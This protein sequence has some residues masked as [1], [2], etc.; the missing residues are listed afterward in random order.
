VLALPARSGK[1]LS[2]GAL[3]TQSGVEFAGKMALIIIRI[4]H[5]VRQIG[6]QFAPRRIVRPG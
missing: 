1:Y 6:R 4:E 5:L 3:R 2:A